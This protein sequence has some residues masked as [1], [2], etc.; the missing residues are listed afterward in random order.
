MEYKKYGD[1]YL[2]R[3]KRG[4]EVM[5]KL[6]ELCRKENILLASIEGIGAASKVVMG[7]FDFDTRHYAKTTYEGCG[8]LELSSLVGSVTELNGEPYLHVHVTFAGEDG[9]AHAGHLN[10]TVIAVTAEIVVRCLDGHAKRSFD[11]ETG[12]NLIN[13]AL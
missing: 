7:C 6:S 12:I 11:E 3:I 8:T 2:V 1:T 5:E 4:E 9:I 13:L 10:E